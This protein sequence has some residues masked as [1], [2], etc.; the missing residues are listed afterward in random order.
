M[1]EPIDIRCEAEISVVGILPVII[2]QMVSKITPP[3]NIHIF[4]ET[5]FDFLQDE[6]QTSAHTIMGQV[7]ERELRI[8]SRCLPVVTGEEMLIERR[9]GQPFLE[10]T[11]GR[12]KSYNL[13]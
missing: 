12:T 4:S 7:E 9:L 11:V 5:F 13:G 2:R 8:P 10:F 1:K 6:M 3:R